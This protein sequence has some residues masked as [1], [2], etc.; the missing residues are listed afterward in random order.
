[1]HVHIWLRGICLGTIET[2]LIFKAS[3]LHAPIA[4]ACQDNSP[5][6]GFSSPS[7]EHRSLSRPSLLQ[8]FSSPSF[9]LYSW[10]VVLGSM[11]MIPRPLRFS[12]PILSLFA[13]IYDVDFHI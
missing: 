2:I 8:G 1:M 4:P 9:R 7:F 13:W 10:D 3:V 6:S 5:S 11:Q 12:Q